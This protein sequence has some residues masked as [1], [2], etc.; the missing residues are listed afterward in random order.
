MT[1]EPP[2]TTVDDIVVVGQR[3]RPGGSFPPASTSGGGGGG[4]SGGVDQDEVDP[5]TQPSGESHPCDDPETAVPWNADAAA[6]AA[7][8]AFLQAASQLGGDD[9]P[10]GD[11]QLGNR[12]FGRGLA[13]GINGSVWGNAVSWGDPPGP[14]G[15]SSFYLDF[16]GITALDYIGDVHSH[17]N[18]NPL[19][20]QADWDGFMNNNR[21]ARNAGRTGETFYLY[22]VTVDS[23]GRPSSIYVYQD[24]PRSAT[25]ADP[26]RPTQIGPEVNPDAQTCT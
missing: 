11:A 22:I 20:S 14:D 19:P 9:A 23:N 5:D 18:G 17:P 8:A 7:I 1:Q 26:A 3:R 10:G 13:R 21:Q 2:E 4:S 24:G 12:E 25:S 15:V 16:A 6:A